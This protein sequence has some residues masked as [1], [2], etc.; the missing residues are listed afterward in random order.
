VANHWRVWYDGG[1]VFD[2]DEISWEALPD[3]GVQFVRVDV[4]GLGWRTMDGCDWYFKA[5]D[6]IACNNDAPDEILRRYPGAIL[7]RGRWT[8]DE[9]T[10]RIHAEAEGRS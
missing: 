5:G 10:T 1:R 2:S 3:D 7:K 6:L 4:E 9:E 8:S